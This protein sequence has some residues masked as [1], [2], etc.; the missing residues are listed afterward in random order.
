MSCS[1]L[2]SCQKKQV[3][4]SVEIRT[5][6]VDSV[7]DTGVPP[8]LHW[9]VDIQDKKGIEEVTMQFSNSPNLLAFPGIFKN[10][11]SKSG[12]VDFEVDSVPESWTITVIVRDQ[13]GTISEQTSTVELP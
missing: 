13:E 10:T 5:T 6:I 7:V 4:G 2:Y 12:R 3:V 11:W 1:L 8:T 9:L